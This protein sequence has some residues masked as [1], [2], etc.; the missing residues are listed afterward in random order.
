MAFNCL[1]VSRFQSCSFNCQPA[2]LHQGRGDPAG[3]RWGG[4]G[5]R[6]VE[7][8]PQVQWVVETAPHVQ[9]VV[10]SAPQVQR[11]KPLH[12]EPGGFKRWFQLGACTPTARGR[13]RPSRHNQPRR[14][15][16]PRGVG[17]GGAS[18]QRPQLESA[19]W[20]HSKVFQR[21]QKVSKVRNLMKR[22]L[23]FSL[24]LVS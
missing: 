5:C 12:E 22:N 24:N 17:G 8:S 23:L 20:F 6:V 10:E 13:A 16:R 18:K 15:R 4:A 11:L 9:W 14:R 2:R 19:S 7:S 21:F 3:A 1:K